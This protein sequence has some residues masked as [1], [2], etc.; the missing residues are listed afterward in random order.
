MYPCALPA[1]VSSRG[2]RARKAAPVIIHKRD[3][4]D[5]LRALAPPPR[6]WPSAPKMLQRRSAF[7]LLLLAALPLLPP[8]P[9]GRRQPLVARGGRKGSLGRRLLLAA[10]ASSRRPAPPGRGRE[11]MGMGMEGGEPGAGP[12]P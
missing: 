3:G 2:V 4:R 10:G 1:P 12:G 9:G 6:G 5:G 8:P 7:P 11:G